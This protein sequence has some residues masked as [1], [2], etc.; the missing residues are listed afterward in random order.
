MLVRQYAWA[1]ASLG[2]GTHRPSPNIFL[3]LSILL[4]F[5]HIFYIHLQSLSLFA[6]SLM[7]SCLYHSFTPSHAWHTFFNMQIGDGSRLMISR[8]TDNMHIK[9]IERPPLKTHSAEYVLL[10]PLSIM[11]ISK[12]LSNY[13]SSFKSQILNLVCEH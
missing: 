13:P 9:A 11:F 7:L 10:T 8:R 4:S 12:R 1:S 6:L 3:S 5:S 2:L